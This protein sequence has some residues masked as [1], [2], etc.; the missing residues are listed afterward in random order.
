MAEPQKNRRN[1]AVTFVQILLPEFKRRVALIRSQK[2]ELPVIRRQSSLKPT[3]Y[4]REERK[5]SFLENEW[6]AFKELREW[7]VAPQYLARE[8][9]ILVTDDVR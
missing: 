7:L 2:G 6:G 5:A 4:T 3:H 1:C 9:R 8:G